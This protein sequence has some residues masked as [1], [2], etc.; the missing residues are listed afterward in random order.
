MGQACYNSKYTDPDKLITAQ[1]YL[2]ERMCERRAKDLG[3]SLVYQFWKT[4]KWNK[5]FLLQLR[6][7]LKLLKD[8]SVKAIL[9]AMK[10]FPK[11]YSLGLKPLRQAAIAHQ[12]KI[13]KELSRTIVQKV[14]NFEYVVSASGNTRP[15]F[16]TNS[17]YSRL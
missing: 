4:P 15:A 5:Y 8:C 14:D 1:Q 13:D 10:D 7:A 9:L 2:A 12:D 17:L 16:T 6:H 3:E 11:A